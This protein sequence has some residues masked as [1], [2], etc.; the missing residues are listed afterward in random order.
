[1]SN[2]N[3]VPLN[4]DPLVGD[5]DKFVSP[6]ETRTD[7]QIAHDEAV[8]NRLYMSGGEGAEENWAEHGALQGDDGETAAP[9]AEDKFE[10]TERDLEDRRHA[11]AWLEDAAAGYE[12]LAEKF[13]RVK[14]DPDRKGVSAY[15]QVSVPPLSE[16]DIVE[17]K[18][19]NRVLENGFYA[20]SDDN[21]YE[22]LRTVKTGSLRRA[23]YFS[24]WPDGSYKAAQNIQTTELDLDSLRDFT[25]RFAQLQRRREEMIAQNGPDPLPSQMQEAFGLAGTGSLVDPDEAEG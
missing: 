24:S 20:T 4:E 6:S 19:L 18:A 13:G 1:M 12:K 10:F 17:S 9:N 25:G 8:A 11:T 16:A 15:A 23:D 5:V 3:Q 7:E 21:V 22:A 2:H 14:G